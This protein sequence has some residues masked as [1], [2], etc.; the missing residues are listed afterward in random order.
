[1][2]RNKYSLIETIYLVLS[3]QKWFGIYVLFVD[4]LIRK[5]YDVQMRTR[6]IVIS[7]PTS[8][9]VVT[10]HCH[11]GSKSMEIPQGLISCFGYMSCVTT[12]NCK[13]WIIFT[14][15]TMKHRI[16]KSGGLH[17]TDYKL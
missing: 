7:I 2:H 8:I 11:Y 9:P 14:H 1:M 3:R 15:N 17:N 6:I 16:C 13:G 10:V 12:F 5:L 4:L